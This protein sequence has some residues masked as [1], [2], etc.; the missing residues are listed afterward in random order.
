MAVIL[1][2]VSDRLL[3]WGQSFSPGELSCHCPPII[4]IDASHIVLGLSPRASSK[5]RRRVV[6]R[7]PGQVN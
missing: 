5:R 3:I 7:A 2:I 4:K 6:P 1:D